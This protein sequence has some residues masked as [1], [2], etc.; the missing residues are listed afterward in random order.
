MQHSNGY[1]E[2]WA[3]ASKAGHLARGV[4]MLLATASTLFLLLNQHGSFSQMGMAAAMCLLCFTSTDAF[5]QLRRFHDAVSRPAL[6]NELK[7]DGVQLTCKPSRQ[8]PFPI[9]REQCRAY[10][11][12]REAIALND[13]RLLELRPLQPM[14]RHWGT[15]YTYF[16]RTLFEAWWPDINLDVAEEVALNAFPKQRAAVSA[17]TGLALVTLVGVAIYIRVLRS[18]VHPAPDGVWLI[19]LLTVGIAPLWPA[20][21]WDQ[22]VRDKAVIQLPSSDDGPAHAKGGLDAGV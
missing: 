13:G 18:I 2:A 16:T 8:A 19:L 12:C 11:P 5:L 15:P 3:E 9:L 14:A 6:R 21:V 7:F 22:S 20:Y 17:I 4:A 10:Y 1:S